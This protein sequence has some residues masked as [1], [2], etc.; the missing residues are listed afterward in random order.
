MGESVVRAEIFAAI[1]AAVFA[2]MIAGHQAGDFWVQASGQAAGKGGP[3]D[4]EPDEVGEWLAG[5]GRS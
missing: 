1:F 3:V 4:W 5:T 2:A